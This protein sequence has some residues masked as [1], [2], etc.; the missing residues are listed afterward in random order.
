MRVAEAMFAAR[1]GNVII[2]SKRQQ[3]LDRL[4]HNLARLFL[5]ATVVQSMT[6]LKIKVVSR[7]RIA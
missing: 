7:F 5:V 4:K 1:F 2:L 3:V 6:S